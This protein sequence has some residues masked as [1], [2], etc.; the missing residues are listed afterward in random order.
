M[1]YVLNGDNDLREAA[2]MDLVELKRSGAPENTNIVA[3]LYRGE[4]KWNLANLKKKMGGLF[5]PEFKPAVKPDWRGMKVYEVSSDSRAMRVN[6]PNPVASPSDPKALEDFVAWGMEQY[7][8]EH[9]AVVLTGHGSQRGTLSDSE[10]RFMP[11]EKVSQSLKSAAERT[12]EQIDLV[13]FDSCSTA[14]DET[15][16]KMRGA[17]D[18]L[19]ATPQKADGHGWSEE[20]TLN[21]LKENPDATPAEFAESYLSPEHTSVRNPLLYDLRD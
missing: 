20:L 12:G 16:E 14:G 17:T 10:G 15:A 19:V 3:Q 5:K 13:L 9:Y 18:F 6:Y 8:A 1:L 4:L 11:F 2:T 21:Y 7:P